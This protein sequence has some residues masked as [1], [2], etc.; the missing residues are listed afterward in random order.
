MFRSNKAAVYIEMNDIEKAIAICE[1]ALAIAKEHRVSYEDKAKLYQRIAAA[2]V[3]DNNDEAAIEAYKKAQMEN[4]D[5]A[6]ERKMKNLELEMKKK[7]IA[8]YVDPV[9]GLEAKERGNVAFRDGNFADAINEYEDAVKRD[10][11]NASYFNNLAATLLKVGD[12]MGAK[13]NVEKALEI[14]KKYVKAWAKKGDIEF[15]MKEY[16]KAMDSYKAGMQIEPDNKLC[17]DGLQKT[18]SKVNTGSAEDQQERQAHALADPEIQMILQDPSIR[19]VLNDFQ[20]NPSHAQRAMGDA[21]IR[22]KIEKLIA[23]GVL[24]VK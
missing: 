6:I 16:H 10:P 19:Q 1:E 7:A 12:F 11:T 14:D 24:Q 20:E 4:F 23:A 13:K 15:F 5:K 17:K 3:K 21:N 18:I 8:A 2:H 9:K 22:A